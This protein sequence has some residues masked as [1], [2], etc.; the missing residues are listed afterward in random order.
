MPTR[1]ILSLLLAA[2]AASLPDDITD[3]ATQFRGPRFDNFP[4]NG[5]PQS[6]VRAG[7][8]RKRAI[9]SGQGSL[10]IVNDR[11]FL[12]AFDE[13]THS[14]AG[15]RSSR[16]RHR[17][18]AGCETRK[19]RRLLGK[20]GT[21]AS[22][23]CASD[24]KRVITYFGS[25]G[26]LC[27][28]VDGQ[29]LWRV[30]M[31]L[32]Q[33]KDGFGSGTSP[34]VHDGR[35]YLLRDEDGPGQG[36]YA[37]DVKT[38]KEIWK[39]KRDGFRVSFGSPVIWDGSVVVIGDLRVKGYDPKT[40]IDRWV[41]RGL[42]AYPCTTPAPGSDGNL[43]VAT[44]SNGSSNE[45]NVPEWKVF[46]ASMDKDK[47]GKLS[48]ADADGTWLADFFSIFDQNKS[49]FI[50]PE[51]W[52]S[53]VDFMA[54]GKNVVLAIRPGGRGDVTDT[55][56]LWSNEK[57]RRMSPYFTTAAFIVKDGG[58]L[59]VYEGATGRLWST[60]SVSACQAILR[61]SGRRRRIFVAS[62]SGTIISLKPGEK[63][64]I[65]TKA[66]LGESI[67]ATPAVVENTLYVRS[68]NH[69]WAFGEKAAQ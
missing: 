15:R 42:A 4:D 27:H 53:S 2:S 12:T 26:L 40:G 60:K 25:F 64:E 5:H 20:V 49:G 59:T 10:C 8:C 65:L 24:G 50:E 28:D 52:Q 31:P 18:A 7:C 38:G 35:V 39:R 22:S 16:R 56:V 30:P 58:L 17:L 32:P 14:N 67:T 48:K 46:L 33:T 45:R 57:A 19:A 43:Y 51:E 13:R 47:D 54:R 37:F 6:S 69:L 62:Q 55:H 11:I 61:V 68:A 36:L 1:L 41:V 21:P 34:I 23:T 29:E 63:P 3:V 66:N 9:P 44:W